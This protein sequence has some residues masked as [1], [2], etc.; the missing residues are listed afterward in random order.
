[1]ANWFTRLFSKKEKTSEQLREQVVADLP[2]VLVL[3]ESELVSAAE[4]PSLE[5]AHGVAMQLD[6]P[7]PSDKKPFEMTDE[8]LEGRSGESPYW[9][10]EWCK[11]L[12]SNRAAA[13][14]DGYVV[15]DTAIVLNQDT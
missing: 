15:Q 2:P 9:A 11:R 8:E 3:K 4:A 1:M 12:M 6:P 13:D 14:P 5:I 10:N 7:H